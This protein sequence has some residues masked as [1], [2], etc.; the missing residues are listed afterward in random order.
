MSHTRAHISQHNPAKIYAV[1]QFEQ[2]VARF[3]VNQALAPSKREKSQH[4][5]KI[6]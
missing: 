5:Q 1:G 3:Y 4:S 2:A 6:V